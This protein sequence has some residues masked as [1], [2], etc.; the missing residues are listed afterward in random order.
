MPESLINVLATTSEL[1][2]IFSDESVLEAMLRFEVALAKAEAEIGVIPQ[3]AANAIG[4]V[5]AAPKFDIGELARKALRAGTLSIPLAQALAGRVHTLDPESARFVHWGATSQDVSDTAMVL[6]LQRALTVF[7]ADHDRLQKA[8]RR[9]AEEHSRTVMLGRTLLQPA[10]PVTFGLKAAGWLAAQRRS[11]TRLA[12]AFEE[13]RVLQ[14]GGASGTLAALGD[15]GLAVSSAL[16][17]ELTLLAPEAPWHTQRDRLAALVCACGVYVGALAKMARDIVLLMQHEV[18]EAAE[19][20]G[21]GR[22]GS[23][24]MPHKHNPIACSLTLAAATRIPGQVASFLYG[25]VQEH[26]RAVGGW[27]AEWVTIS[28]VVQDT[29]VALASMR[30]TAEGLRVDPRKMSGNIASTQGAIFAEKARF[31]GDEVNEDPNDYLGAAEDFRKR[32]LD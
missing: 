29:G 28:R 30:E 21:D 27:Q 13:S 8:L 25:M 18:G 7:S 2:E 12:A 19:P 14:F 6:L 26:E 3:S 16:A 22:G 15:K 9:L 11:W 23:S 31:F 5:A 4:R 17:R 32:L 20:G 10:P 24:T 1:R